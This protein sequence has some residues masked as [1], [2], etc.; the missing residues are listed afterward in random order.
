MDCFEEKESDSSGTL[1][2]ELWRKLVTYMHLNEEVDRERFFGYLGIALDNVGFKKVKV[3]FKKGRRSAYTGLSFKS[4]VG[5]FN[6]DAR[7]PVK[8]H[9][10]ATELEKVQTW[11]KNS[12]VEG[13]END[14]IAK[15]DMWMIFQ[16]DVQVKEVTKSVFFSLLGNTVFKNPP[17]LKVSGIKREGKVSHYQYLQERSHSTDKKT[18]ITLCDEAVSESL[19]DDLS[20]M[21]SD[22]TECVFN[23]V[24]RSGK[25]TNNL[26]FSP[27]CGNETPVYLS[28]ESEEEK[29]YSDDHVSQHDD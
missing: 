24:R 11:I 8:P 16:R 9:R 28:S 5:K 6:Q 26:F 19:E 13:D 17:Y 2:E 1:K 15:E 18:R 10:N 21:M 12:F 23:E 27:K 22:P 20:G 3:V 4:N 29:A 7:T 14:R 25:K